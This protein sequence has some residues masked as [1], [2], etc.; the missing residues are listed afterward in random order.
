LCGGALEVIDVHARPERQQLLAQLDPHRLRE[1][2]RG[3]HH[4]VEVV[5]GRP[6]V[7]LGPQRLHE[8]LAMQPMVRCERHE[9]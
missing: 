3:V 7:Q 9:L 6:L 2:T 8:L 1:S 4:L 5:R